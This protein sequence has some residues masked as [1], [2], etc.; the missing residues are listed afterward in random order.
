MNLELG[1]VLTKNETVAEIAY[2][3]V[4]VV[5]T[6]YNHAKY[7]PEAIDSILAQGVAD[8]EIVLVDDGSTD[9]TKTVAFRYKTVKYVYQKNQGLSAARNTG[10]KESKGDYLVFLDADD[11]LMP[12]SLET[13]SRILDENP[14]AAFVFG[15]HKL[16]FE[17]TGNVGHVRKKNLHN[18]Y[19]HFLEDGN[20]IGMH[21]TVM[22]RRW[23][24]DHF[25]YDTSLK[26]CEDYDIYLK[27]TRRFPVI[28]HDGFIATYRFHDTNMSGN[29]PL[30]IES[31]LDVLSRQ[32]QN[33]KDTTEK[34][35][36]KKGLRFWKLYYSDLIYKDLFFSKTG[37]RNWMNNEREMLWKHSKK[38]YLK[39]LVKKSL[40]PYVSSIKRRVP[41]FLLRALH[42][43]GLYGGF[44][45]P[46]GKVKL[47][48]LN[49]TFPLSTSFGYDRG[50]PVDRYYIEGFLN[51]EKDKVAGRVLEIAD[52][53]Y[54][55]KFGGN[56]VTKSDILHIDDSND[57]ATII[58][59][60]TNAPHI[61]DN[62]FD[63]FI[64]TQTLHLIYDYKKAI[65]TAYRILKPGGVLL[66][67]VPGITQIDRGDWYKH[68]LWSF[69]ETVIRKIFSEVFPVENTEVA[70]YGN[71]LSATAFLYGMGLSELKKE[72]LDYNDPHYQVIISVKA[73]KPLA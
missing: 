12:E 46:I 70:S 20:F 29:T 45:P 22:Y 35:C 23:V 50:G 24:F 11:W 53:E 59:D 32:E 2:P 69:T 39:A 13:N 14:E 58:G 47:G 27:I 3:A 61:D 60:L 51:E 63:C 1:E 18:Y 5:I 21:A 42:K 37:P 73:V 68:W 4:S 26:A 17:S 7:L 43:A 34:K 25:L 65:E 49:R 62:T 67:T 44:M 64:L 16:F 19:Q 28:H 66:V 41:I 36:F 48:D 33:L 10:I 40:M 30:M 55:L 52:N 72:Q 9:D 57:K 56:K 31:A 15:A 6:C 8:V 71:V 54:T 38:L